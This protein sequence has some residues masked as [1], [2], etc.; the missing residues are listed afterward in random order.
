[1]PG[2]DAYLHRL[3]G[4]T[5]TAG[6]FPNG[7]ADRLK[8]IPSAPGVFLGQLASG[9]LLS[10][11]ATS[12]GKITVLRISTLGVVVSQ[13]DL[14]SDGAAGTLATADLNGDGIA[15]LVTPLVTSGGVTG[16]G[17]FL[18]RDDGSFAPVVVYPGYAAT[19]SASRFGQPRRLNGDGKIDIV[20]IAGGFAGTSNPTVV[21]LLGTGAGSLRAGSSRVMPVATGPFVLADFNGDRR[22]D[23]VTSG[24]SFVPGNGDGSFGTPVQ[25]LTGFNSGFTSNLAVGDFNGDGRL[26]IVRRTGRS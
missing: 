17:V 16:V 10:A 22:I 21:T 14:V 1:M 9:D 23:L 20:A 11:V 2:A 13:T 8:G 5:T 25:A 15:D 26:D 18:G 6:T 12:T 4:L 19:P 3:S 24:G 7:C